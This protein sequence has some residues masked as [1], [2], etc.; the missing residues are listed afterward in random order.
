MIKK[1]KFAL[2]LGNK[3]CRSLE[4]IRENFDVEDIIKNFD[5]G[6]LLKWLKTYN[7]NE[8]YDKPV[9]IDKGSR[10]R[11]DDLLYIFIEDE[12]KR[13]EIKSEYESNRTE[14]DIR[15][16]LEE[17]NSIFNDHEYIVNSIIENNKII[18]IDK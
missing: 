12:N 11:L 18:N 8:L 4:D 3:P 6:V 17:E 16:A 15:K 7:L 1:I 10:N 13:E 9:L 2:L 14:E 5:N